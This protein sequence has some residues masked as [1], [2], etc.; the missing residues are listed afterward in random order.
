MILITTA[1][2]RD[3]IVFKFRSL[4]RRVIELRDFEEGMVG[5]ED[6]WSERVF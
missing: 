3:M 5:L 6:V 4:S 2:R 1:Y